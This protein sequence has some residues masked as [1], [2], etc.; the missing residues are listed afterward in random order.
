MRNYFTSAIIRFFEKLKLPDVYLEFLNPEIE[1]IFFKMK[2]LHETQK[3][4]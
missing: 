1:L 3:G 4:L 2:Y